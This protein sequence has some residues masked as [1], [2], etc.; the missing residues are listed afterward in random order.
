ML[1]LDYYIL[2]KFIA[3]S[4]KNASYVSSTS[5]VQSLHINISREIYLTVQTYTIDILKPYSTS[6]KASVRL[7]PRIF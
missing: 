7:A 3:Y 6:F 4:R 2:P 1:N 5:L